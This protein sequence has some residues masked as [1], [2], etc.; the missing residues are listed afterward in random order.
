LRI[1]EIFE[2]HKKTFSFEFFPPKNYQSTLELGINIG[3][4][5]KLSP[6]FIS[7]TYGAGGSTQELSFDLIDYIQ[8]KIGLTAMAHYTCVNA[9]KEK[10][11]K[12]LALLV[13]KGIENLMLIRGDLPP[14]G[15]DGLNREFQHAS[16]LI[17][18]ASSLDAFSIGAAGYPENHPESSN[19]E[20]D[21]KWMKYKIDQGA[22]FIITQMFFD[23]DLYFDFVQKA[24]K[25]NITVRI[26]PGIM[27]IT[28]YNQIS[29]F[30]KMCGATIPQYIKDR[31]EPIKND[32]KKIYRVGVEI[33]IEQCIDLLRRG[34]PGLHFYTL[35]KSRA[36]VD[37]YSS[38]PHGLI[39]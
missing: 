34:A 21:M 39:S 31:L 29:K 28:N 27:P 9:N 16:D 8:N 32:Q 37:I 22:D 17:S 36:T 6:S 7:V 2:Y 10:V 1:T 23:N 20:D 5:L 15:F 4:L 11:N 18:I 35:N 12:D 38:I 30:S 26:I 33:A 13:S 24:R 3:Q 25:E 19:T 14:S